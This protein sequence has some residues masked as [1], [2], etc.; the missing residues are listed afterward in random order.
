MEVVVTIPVVV[1]P[2]G[3][4]EVLV[5]VAVEVPVSCNEGVSVIVRYF[6]ILVFPVDSPA[7]VEVLLLGASSR[8]VLDC[9]ERRT[10]LVETTIAVVFATVVVALEASLAV[11]KTVVNKVR[12]VWTDVGSGIVI[13]LDTVAVARSRIMSSTAVD[14]L[15]VLPRTSVSTMINNH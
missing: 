4:L 3:V 7:A 14:W 9:V 8:I 15:A 11:T 13:L 2:N 5:L 1:G 6:E 10:V 12:R